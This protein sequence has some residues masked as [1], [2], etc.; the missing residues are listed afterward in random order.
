MPCSY[1]A[2]GN[3]QLQLCF[4]LASAYVSCC[5][6]SRARPF[7]ADDLAV[8]TNSSDAC[9]DFH[10]CTLIKIRL[11]TVE[12]SSI[13]ENNYSLKRRH[14]IQHASPPTVPFKSPTGLGHR[15]GCPPRSRSPPPYAQNG[16]PAAVLGHD[17]PAVVQQLHIPPP[18]D[19]HGLDRQGHARPQLKVAAQLL[20]GHEIRRP[21]GLRASIGRCRGRRTRAPR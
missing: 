11:A 10:D 5:C 3:S 16:P 1:S 18:S 6:R 8:L 9:S 15:S 21:S 7:A 17:R 19:H 13:A 2:T 14:A 12:S 4:I 20:G